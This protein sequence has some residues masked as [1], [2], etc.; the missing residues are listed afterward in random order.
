MPTITLTFGDV[1]ENG[2]GMQKIGELKEEGI[3]FSFLKDFYEKNKKKFN[4]EFIQLNDEK[5]KDEEEACLLILRNG[6]K[7]LF[8]QSFLDNLYNEQNNLKPDTKALMRGRVVNKLARHN[9]CFSKNDQQADIENG[10]GTI[11]SFD[12]IPYTKELKEKI[13]ELFNDSNY[14]ECEGNYYYDIKKCHIGFH[15]DTERRIVIGV[16]LGERFPIIFQWY[17]KF[18]STSDKKITYLNGGDIYIMSSKATGYDWKKSSIKTLRHAA[19]F[20]WI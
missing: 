20:K 13:E 15:G 4:L 11:I 19:G 18:E 7:D 2:P 10:K 6:V 16:R 3:E 14:L 9:L 5:N 17:K 12:K 1:C 8:S